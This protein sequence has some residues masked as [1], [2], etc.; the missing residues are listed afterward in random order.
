MKNKQGIFNIG[1][2]L[3]IM[4]GM[5][6]FV[7]MLTANAQVSIIINE[8]DSDTPSTDTLEF[9]ELYDGGAGNTSLNG[10]VLV[11]F[12]GS[13]DISYSAFDLDGYSTNDNGYFLLGNAA[14]VPSPSIIFSD[15]TLQNGA[16]AVALYAGNATDFPINTPV[17]TTNLID[18]VVYDTNDADD[19]GLL[20]LVSS[21]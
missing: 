7:P 16:D 9:I 3:T 1:L 14:V 13:S 15:N 12:N 20:M 17:T 5:I 4:I 10:L 2:A 11:L 19:A 8:L 18:A 21:F 6:G